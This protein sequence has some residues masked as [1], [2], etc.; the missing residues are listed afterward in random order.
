MYR[1]KLKSHTFCLDIVLV[2]CVKNFVYLRLISMYMLNSITNYHF[3]T[4]LETGSDDVIALL[5]INRD[6]TSC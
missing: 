3:I 1:R 6:D 4:V 5:A 2:R